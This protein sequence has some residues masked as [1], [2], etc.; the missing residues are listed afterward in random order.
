MNEKTWLETDYKM[1]AFELANRILKC[2]QNML[3]SSNTGYVMNRYI[4]SSIRLVEGVIDYVN[5]SQIQGSAICCDI[6]NAFDTVDINVL[7]HTL[8]KINFGD[9]IIEWIKYSTTM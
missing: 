6:E 5:T 7:L 2:W 8:K 9:Q 3:T 4:G 1:T